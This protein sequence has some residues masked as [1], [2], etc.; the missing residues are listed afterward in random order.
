MLK[1][2]LLGLALT[3]VLALPVQAYVIYIPYTIR[4]PDPEIGDYSNIHTI[5]LVSVIGGKLRV[6]KSK[7]LLAKDTAYRDIADWKID[8]LVRDTAHETLGSRFT[9]VDI[10]TDPVSVARQIDPGL[11]VGNEAPLRAFLKSLDHPEVDAYL[12]VRPRYYASF[13]G[14]DAGLSLEAFPDTRE[15]W[16]YANYEI[17]LVD[18]HTLKDIAKSFARMRLEDGTPPRFP[19]VR[20]PLTIMPDDDLSLDDHAAL[21]TQKWMKLLVRLSMIETLR[22]LQIGVDLPRAGGREV[23]ARP[24][25]KLPLPAGSN[26]AVVSA[27]GDTLFLEHHGT[28]FRNSQRTFET[29]DTALDTRIEQLV[30][31]NLDQRF[32][33]KPA[34]EGVDRSKIVLHGTKGV[35]DGLPAAPGIDAYILVVK[36]NDPGNLGFSR[37]GLGLINWTPLG[38][39]RTIADANFEIVVVDA[40]S[41]REIFATEGVANPD[42]QM[43][44]PQRDIDSALYPDNNPLTPSGREALRDAFAGLLSDSVPETLLRLGFSGK[45]L[46]TPGL[47]TRAPKPMAPDEEPGMDSSQHASAPST[48]SGSENDSARNGPPPKPQV[49]SP[50]P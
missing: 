18:A 16:L 40:H 45:M 17:T 37:N 36:R 41:F 47:P 48:A 44:I 11:F 39:E 3:C 30:A 8:D 10:P 4:V 43:V 1:R 35:Y 46:I 19:G 24:N 5:G 50:T 14:T 26:L 38:S 15:S 32:H 49:S 29:G 25:D 21:T 20:P 7:G 2:I 12:V 42:L 22:A 33:V 13:P 6:F 23:V 9:I 34:P 27:L 28:M 31:A